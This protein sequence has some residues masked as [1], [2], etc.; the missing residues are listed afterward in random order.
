LILLGNKLH[1]SLG[2]QER[3]DGGI[4]EVIKKA[5][6]EVNGINLHYS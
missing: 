1:L 2:K 4:D 3:H 6:G 5:V